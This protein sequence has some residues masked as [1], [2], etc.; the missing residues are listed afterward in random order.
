MAEAAVY[1]QRC[2]M[3][4]Q[5]GHDASAACLEGLDVRQDLGSIAQARQALQVMVPSR[6]SYE[7]PFRSAHQTGKHSIHIV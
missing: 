3:A 2:H 4:K 5:Q 1:L 7:L 6:L